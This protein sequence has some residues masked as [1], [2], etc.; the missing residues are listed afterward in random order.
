MFCFFLYLKE[1][2]CVCCLGLPVLP[3][4]TYD[5][6]RKL[7]IN[8]PESVLGIAESSRYHSFKLEVTWLFRI[9]W[10]GGGVLGV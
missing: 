6:S 10:L 8:L 9:A 4:S 2:V 5:I 1:F 7:L 3:S